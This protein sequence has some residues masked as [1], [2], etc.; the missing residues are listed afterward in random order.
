MA[1]RDTIRAWNYFGKKEPLWAILNDKTKKE[2]A[3][4]PDEFF[5]TGREEIERIM[6][7][8][9]ALGIAP[10]RGAALDFGCGAGRL[11][12]ALTYFFDRV[13]GVDAAPSMIALARHYD[14]SPGTCRYILNQ[15][16]NLGVLPDNSF[17]LIYSAITLQ[18]M[19]PQ[20]AALYIREFVR[21][22]RQGGVVVFQLPSERISPPS[23]ARAT[24]PHILKHSIPPLFLRVW[25]HLR[26]GTQQFIEMYGTKKETVVAILKDAGASVADIRENRDAGDN[27]ISFRY[28]AVKR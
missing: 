20:Y 28:Y 17:D 19:E 13:I 22:A 23:G 1:L 5:K 3:W 8:L 10:A 15:T 11:T 12:Q 14:G 27:W 18:H 4:D 26:Y 2:N 21:I 7:D 24:R 6:E 25:R 9:S 16:S